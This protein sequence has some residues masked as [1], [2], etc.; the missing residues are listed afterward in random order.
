MT[1]WLLA[2]TP[3][4]FPRGHQVDDHLGADC[5]LSRPGRPLDR[6][7]ALVR[8]GSQ[9]ACCVLGVLAL[10]EKGLPL[11]LPKPRWLAREQVTCCPVRTRALDAMLG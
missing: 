7:V 4:R 6:E 10:L 8:S 3:M 1:L 5:A 9:S 2:V 11:S